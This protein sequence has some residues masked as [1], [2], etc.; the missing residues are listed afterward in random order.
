MVGVLG[1]IALLNNTFNLG[2]P[3]DARRY[4]PDMSRL[5]DIN[6]AYKFVE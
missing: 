2:V 5:K 1:I 6:S 3:P 4:E